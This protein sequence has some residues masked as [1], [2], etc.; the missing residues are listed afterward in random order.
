MRKLTGEAKN[1]VSGILLS[2][3]NYAVTL[4]LLR[5]RY[6]DTQAVVSSHYTDLINL[7]SALYTPKGLCSLYNKIEKKHMRCLKA[8]EQGINQDIFYHNDHIQTTKRCF[9][10]T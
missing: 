6:K 1:S 5:E 3:E 4:E 9:I 10:S 2:N 7:K 8:L